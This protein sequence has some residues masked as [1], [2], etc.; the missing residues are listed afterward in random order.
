LMDACIDCGHEAW[1]LFGFIYDL[2]L[3]TGV[4]STG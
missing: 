4:K 3:R 1:H 2:F